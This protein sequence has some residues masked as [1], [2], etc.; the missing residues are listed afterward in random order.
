VRDYDYDYDRGNHVSYRTYIDNC[1]HH[2]ST[3]ICHN[4]DHGNDCIHGG[5]GD[6]SGDDHDGARGDDW[7]W[8]DRCV[9]SYNGGRRNDNADNHSDDHDYGNDNNGSLY[10][11]R[12][13]GRLR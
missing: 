5:N 3:R 11:V 12:D 1:F 4:G 10:N 8:Y 9:D 7:I 6:Y 2:N 13:S